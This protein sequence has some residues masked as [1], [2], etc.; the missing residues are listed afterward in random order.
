[1]A[2]LEEGGARAA[3]RVGRNAAI[4]AATSFV[5][6]AGSLAVVPF[7]LRAFSTADYGMYSA[8]FA[9]AGL[10]G[11][12]AQFGMNQVVVRDI[13]TG[14]RSKGW[15]V[16]HCAAL[17]LALLVPAAGALFLVGFFK[18]FSPGMWVLAWLAFAVMGLDAVT[19]TVKAA[20]H[21]AERFALVAGVDALRKCAQWGI[22]I[23]VIVVGAGITAL[24]G[25]VVAASVITLVVV[26]FVGVRRRD[27]AAVSFAPGYAAGMLRLAA[28]M[29]I[30]AAFVAALDN[31]DIWLLD[32]LSGFEAVA[33]YKAANVFKPIFFA[34]AVVWAFMPM[35]FRLGRESREGLAVAAANAARFLLVA[36]SATAIVFACGASRIVPLLAGDKY[37]A[38][39]PAF[40][41]MALTLPPVFVGF[42]Y[43]HMLTA[44]DRQ[45]WAVGI[46]AVGL[47][48]NIAGDL[49][50]IP[51]MG[52]AGA[53]LGTLLAET[54]MAIGAFAVA[55]RVVARGANGPLLR[56]A[57]AVA[58]GAV[59]AIFTQ[60]AE[61]ADM[62][63][64]ALAVMG[65]CLVAFGGVSAGDLALVKG[66]FTRRVDHGKD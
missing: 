28:P 33:L 8:A 35:A 66:V 40:R 9:Y 51:R 4:L 61:I 7:I 56:T 41:L 38:S 63:I 20:L 42:L 50:F 31:V 24:A 58:A 22:A 45:I 19:G 16:F 34:H 15:V 37:A 46:F 53:M 26:A 23:G 6:K 14:E 57:A 21:A 30:S 10:L 59:T 39:I 64:G 62:G 12:V 54:L 48:V 52:P 65:V 36:G 13:S 1:M 3:G 43:L 17:R 29:G 25:G 11:I 32:W 27:F 5:C 55:W 60:R 44:V 2:A 18:G 47:V 49:L